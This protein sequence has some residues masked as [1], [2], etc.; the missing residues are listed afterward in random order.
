MPALY[1]AGDIFVLNTFYDACANAV[2]EA[3]ACG[4]P[5]VSTSSNGSSVFLRPEAVTDD[6]ANADDLARRIRSLIHNGSTA[7]TDFNPASGL[8]PY[9]D[10]I[11]EFS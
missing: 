10:L 4:L 8:K 5:T 7:R 3:L 11:R 2:L 9:V 1:Q 6:P